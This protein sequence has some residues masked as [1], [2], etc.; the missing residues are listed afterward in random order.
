[1]EKI[2]DDLLGNLDQTADEPEVLIDDRIEQAALS[3]DGYLMVRLEDQRRKASAQEFANRCRQLQSRLDET[4]QE[5]D[6][7][8]SE[9][10]ALTQQ[11]ELAA[12]Q[13]RAAQNAAHERALEHASIQL[14]LGFLDGKIEVLRDEDH[15]TSEQLRR[16]LATGNRSKN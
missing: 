3:G 5:R 1:M 2:I 11:L 6:H 14:R 8:L 12:T 9:R 10:Q 13:L 7:T 16:L 15:E 4:K